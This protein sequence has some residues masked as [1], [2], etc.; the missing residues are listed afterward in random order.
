[1]RASIIVNGNYNGTMYI[2]GELIIAADGGAEE[3]RKR[4]YYRM[5]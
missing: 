2:T 1:M 4:M 5:S 3:L